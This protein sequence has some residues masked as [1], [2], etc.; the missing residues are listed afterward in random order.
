LELESE[1]ELPEPPVLLFELPVPPVLLFELP[2]P[3]PVLESEL[4]PVEHPQSFP[5]A[6]PDPPD[7]FPFG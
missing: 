3:P 1:L 6:P 7:W 2:E 4:P 5:L